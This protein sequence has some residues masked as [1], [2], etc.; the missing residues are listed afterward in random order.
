ML[1]EAGGQISEVKS[2]VESLHSDEGNSDHNFVMTEMANSGGHVWTLA[3]RKVACEEKDLRWEERDGE[4]STFKST[5]LCLLH[6]AFQSS[7][8]SKL[9]LVDWEV[10]RDVGINDPNLGLLWANLASQEDNLSLSLLPQVTLASGNKNDTLTVILNTT[11]HQDV[12]HHGNETFNS[13]DVT[14]SSPRKSSLRCCCSSM[15]KDQY[16]LKDEQP[17]IHQHLQELP[18]HNK[19]L[20]IFSKIE[21]EA[22]GRSRI[23]SDAM[24]RLINRDLELM[25]EQDTNYNR[26]LSVSHIHCLLTPS[27]T[28]EPDRIDPNEKRFQSSDKDLILRTNQDLKTRT[29]QTS[30]TFGSP[31]SSTRSCDVTT[32]PHYRSSWRDPEHDHTTPWGAPTLP[33]LPTLSTLPT[34]SQL[35]GGHSDS[36]HSP[37]QGPYNPPNGFHNSPHTTH[38]PCQGAESP[39][40]KASR[41]QL[42]GGQTAGHSHGRGWVVGA[43][44]VVWVLPLLLLLPTLV[45]ADTEMRPSLTTPRQNLTVAAGRRARLICVV[46]NLA[47]YKIAWTHY[48]SS[49]R[50]VLTVDTLVITKNQR[51]SLLKERG[52][53]SWSLVIN[54]VTTTDLGDYLC[55]VNTVPPEKLYFHISVVVPPVII[56]PPEDVTVAE[57][58]DVLLECD[59]AG[60]PQ[61]TLTWR[62]EDGAPFSL[63][64]SH[65]VEAAG[66]SLHLVSV[67]RDDSGA[68]YVASNGIPPAVS[69]RAEVSVKLIAPEMRG[70]T[71]VVWVEAWDRATME[72]HY[73]AW[74]APNVTWTKDGDLIEGSRETWVGWGEGASTLLLNTVGPDDFGH[75]RCL[76]TN[77]PTNSS[78]LTLVGSTAPQELGPTDAAPHHVQEA[79]PAHRNPAPPT[80]LLP[81]SI[82]MSSPVS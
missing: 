77:N 23:E 20:T 69:A 37:P 6:Q 42:C 50:A 41:N 70:G 29:D 26:K 21:S 64:N 3:K 56:H 62:R 43:S 59:A 19:D 79:A 16:T 74:P 72:C 47:N 66:P 34:T 36:T 61:P 1:T 51:V 13:N 63:N 46:E 38:S 67:N 71:G 75:Y 33:T 22:E 11:Q 28:E 44:W 45:L 54:N 14:E 53:A 8:S 12:A 35:Y 4:G 48:G 76:V 57:G 25:T 30:Q 9:F 55:Q 58:D 80:M 60:D 10:C 68:F 73:R 17:G 5:S 24:L 27:D 15:I 82:Q 18:N 52:G 2:L 78:M 81:V 40:T 32:T 49:G 31:Y 65:V 7:P 39:H